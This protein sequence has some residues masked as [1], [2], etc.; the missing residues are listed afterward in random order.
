MLLYCHV[1]IDFC[2]LKSDEME[3]KKNKYYYSAIDIIGVKT[4]TFGHAY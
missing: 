4:A 1:C 2:K 3:K